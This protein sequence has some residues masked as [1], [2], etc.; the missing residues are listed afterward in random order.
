[1]AVGYADSM[2]ALSVR[3][4]AG[5]WPATD[6]CCRSSTNKASVFRYSSASGTRLNSMSGRCF[7]AAAAISSSATLTSC[8]MRRLLNS[9]MPRA[10]PA[11]ATRKSTIVV[12]VAVVIIP[13]G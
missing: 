10:I 4:I 3:S 7:F 11:A 9:A 8:H 6:C 1:M 12:I 13:P 2:T 5:S